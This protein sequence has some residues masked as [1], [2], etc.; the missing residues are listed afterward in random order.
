MTK[1]KRP[2]QEVAINTSDVSSKETAND[3]FQKGQEVVKN[4][5]TCHIYP[6][7]VK[8]VPTR[9]LNI[10]ATS[11]HRKWKSEAHDF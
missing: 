1:A 7:V 4:K 2:L 8:C 9:A 6:R 5:V 3:K 10:Q 11:L